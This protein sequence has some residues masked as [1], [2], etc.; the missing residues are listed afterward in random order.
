[1]RP[2]KLLSTVV[3]VA[4]Y[5]RKELWP[6]SRIPFNTGKGTAQEPTREI[7]HDSSLM[8]VQVDISREVHDL[9]AVHLDPI[10]G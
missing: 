3:L 8:D 2:S 7:I 10:P 6:E 5:K 9:D 1:M 4:V